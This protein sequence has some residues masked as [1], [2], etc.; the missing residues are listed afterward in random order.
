M[1]SH[2]SAAAT[3]S[4]WPAATRNGKASAPANSLL[5]ALRNGGHLRTRA[6]K[7][8]VN[9]AILMTKANETII[10]IHNR[11]SVILPLGREKEWLPPGP[12][13]HIVPPFPAELLTDYPVT[14]K[15]NRATFNSPDAITALE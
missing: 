4:S 5:R 2:H 9:F 11:M 7:C 14:P 6:E 10:H 3:A 15:I 13:A 1:F 12:G 8:P